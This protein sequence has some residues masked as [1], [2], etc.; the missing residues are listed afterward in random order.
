[1]DFNELTAESNLGLFVWEDLDTIAGL[2]TTGTSRPLPIFSS[3]SLDPYF[4][5]IEDESGIILDSSRLSGVPL[6][7]K[8]KEMASLLSKLTKNSSLEEVIK[9][10]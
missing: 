6:D 8:D 9:N 4:L 3:I 5:V 1:L 10:S 2:V 7:L